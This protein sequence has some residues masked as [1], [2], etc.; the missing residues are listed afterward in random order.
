MQGLSCR[1]KL[2][3]R[4]VAGYT[5][6]ISSKA[7][8]LEIEDRSKLLRDQ[9]ITMDSTCKQSKLHG[10]VSFA[11]QSCHAPENHISAS[12]WKNM[13]PRARIL[14]AEEKRE[15]SKEGDRCLTAVSA[16]LGQAGDFSS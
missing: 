6:T 10:F 16:W 4:I 9:L 13:Q 7:G 3:T 12:G 2:G 1:S 15:V 8:L 14:D 11:T 5:N